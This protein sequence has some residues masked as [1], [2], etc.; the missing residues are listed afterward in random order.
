MNTAIRGA[1]YLVLAIAAVSV[2]VVLKPNVEAN[3]PSL[4]SATTY[5]SLISTAMSDYDGNNSNTES[6]PQQQVVNGWVARD[7]L[8]IIAKENA[9]ILRAQ[10]AVVDATGALQTAP[11]DERVPALLLLGVLAVCWTGLTAHQPVAAP[12][13]ALPATA[14]QQAL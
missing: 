5:K 9:D 7:L 3:T 6:A 8:L 13:P 2:F 10:G 11:F 4:P 14:P 1:G 12:A